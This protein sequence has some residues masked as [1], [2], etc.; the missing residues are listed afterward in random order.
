MPRVSRAFSGFR[1]RDGSRVQGFRVLDASGVQGLRVYTLGFSFSSVLNCRFR[2]F[3]A[4][5][6]SDLC[7]FLKQRNTLQMRVYV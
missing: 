1:G 6:H 7:S 4:T 2:V 3:R 5:L